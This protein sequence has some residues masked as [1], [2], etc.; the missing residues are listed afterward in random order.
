MTLQ[1]RG[2]TSCIQQ[3]RRHAARAATRRAQPLGREEELLPLPPTLHRRGLP[4]QT[5]QRLHPPHLTRAED[6]R[7]KK[8]TRG[9][10]V[11]LVDGTRKRQGCERCIVDGIRERKCCQ[12]CL[13]DGTRKRKCC[14]RWP[15]GIT[16]LILSR[17]FKLQNFLSRGGKLIIIFGSEK[18]N[19]DKRQEAL[20]SPESATR[21]P[22]PSA[23]SARSNFSIAATT[24]EVTARCPF[25]LPRVRS[26]TGLAHR[27]AT[28]TASFPSAS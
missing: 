16:E 19:A 7:Y 25:S 10:S 5:M 2:T 18:R 28:A 21:P 1:P 26:R 8:E 12:R 20:Y 6:R 23:A 17:Q 27:A 13:V 11:C 24:A 4:T 15:V 14:Q 3:D 9:V 22:P